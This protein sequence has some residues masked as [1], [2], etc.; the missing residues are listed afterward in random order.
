MCAALRRRERVD[1][2]DDDGLHAAQRVAGARREHQ[3]ERLGR[4]DQDVGRVA[5]Q[6]LALLARRVAGAHRDRGRVERRAEAF[7]REGDA[8]ERGAKVLLDVERERAQR[9]DVQDAAAP[10]LRR[11][12]FGAEPV[13]G[14][15]ERRER[16]P[17]PGR[18]EQE[19]VVPARDRGPALGLRVGG[20]GE[21]GVEPGPHRRGEEIDGHVDV[22][23]PLRCDSHPGASPS[24]GSRRQERARAGDLCGSGGT[25]T[26]RAVGA[27]KVHGSP[28]PHRSRRVHHGRIV[29]LRRLRHEEHG[30]PGGG[31]DAAAHER[32]F[33][34]SL[35]DSAVERFA[36]GTRVNPGCVVS[37]RAGLRRPAAAARSVSCTPSRAVVRQHLLRPEPKRG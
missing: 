4:R 11:G 33:V 37:E 6:L 14:R 20:R 31:Q 25:G 7:G 3:V 27:S 29:G 34:A 2:V 30:Q 16:L 12:G 26:R 18:R 8:G 10:V 1:L 22:T 19:R 13:D 21:A 5:H 9:R 24:V 17:R 36:K 15:Q 32:R 35:L 23:V 28:L